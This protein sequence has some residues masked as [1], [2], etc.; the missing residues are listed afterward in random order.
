MFIGEDVGPHTIDLQY[1]SEAVP[2]SPY[3][4][5]I[6]DSHRVQ[7]TD[8]TPCGN[9]GEEIFFT[10]ELIITMQVKMPCY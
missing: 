8:L 5:Y 6:Y 7:V 9:L 10:G 3:T 1:G 4:C 2:G